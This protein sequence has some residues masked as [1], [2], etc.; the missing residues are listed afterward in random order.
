MLKESKEV[1][2]K[3]VKVPIIQ[4]LGWSYQH[5]W[6]GT[7]IFQGLFVNFFRV[8]LVFLCRLA[9][10]VWKTTHRHVGSAA[11][12]PAFGYGVDQ[13]TTDP[14]ITELYIAFPVQQYIGRFHI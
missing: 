10:I 9:E 14:E 7:L 3:P 2:N 5:Y 4:K 8:T 11:S 6:N 12:I 13:L 1:H